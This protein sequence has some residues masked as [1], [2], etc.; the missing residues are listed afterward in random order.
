MSLFVALKSPSLPPLLLHRPVSTEH[1]RLCSIS[2]SLLVLL[3]L[4]EQP[5]EAEGQWSAR[6]IL[7]HYARIHSLS[8][9]Q[10]GTGKQNRPLSLSLPAHLCQVFADAGYATGKKKKK[11][12]GREKKPTP[13]CSACVRDRVH[14][15]VLQ[16]SPSLPPSL[17]LVRYIQQ[18]LL[19][20]I[21]IFVLHQNMSAEHV[22]TNTAQLKTNKHASTCC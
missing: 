22:R 6:A 5:N 18:T 4:S 17:S 20:P 15:Y 19:A 13:D 8:H 12:P 21:K 2:P 11:I 7:P 1:T 14:T 9:K 10:S 3:L 16:S